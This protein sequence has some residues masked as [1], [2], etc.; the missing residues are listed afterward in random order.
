MGLLANF[1]IRTKVFVALLPLAVMVIVA[2]LYASFEMNRIDTRYSELIGRD[3]KAL[4]DL[5]VARVLNNRFGQLL[6]QEIAETDVDRMRVI[7][8]DLDKTA[9]EFH[10]SVEEAKR[11]SPSMAQKI[12][13]ADSHLRPGGCRLPPGSSGDPVRQQ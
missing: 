1:K 11:E 7:D 6:Y 3:V 8:A 9:A 13:A 12:D 5:T 10:S 4:Q 2:A